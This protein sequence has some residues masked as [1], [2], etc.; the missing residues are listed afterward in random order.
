[1]I[2]RTGRVRLMVEEFKGRKRNKVAAWLTQPAAETS[3]RGGVP[4]AN[5]PF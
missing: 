3:T 5:R 4:H 2:G 1:L